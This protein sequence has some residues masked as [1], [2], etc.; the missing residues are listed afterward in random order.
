MATNNTIL[1][2]HF[3]VQR[4]FMPLVTLLNEVEQTD[5]DGEDVS[6]AALREQMTWTGHNP[7][8]DRWVATR[9]DDASLIGYG[10]IFKTPN[11]DCADLYIAVHPAWRRRGVGSELL[12]HLMERAREVGTRVVGAYATVQN[13]AARLF[14]SHHGFDPVA[15]YTRM[16]ILGS[17]SF[18]PPSLPPGFV[19]RSYDQIQRI[20]LYTEATNRSYEGLWGHRHVSQEEVAEWLPHLLPEGIFLLFAP[21]G[22]VVGK[23]Q[24]EISEHLTT[25]RGAPTGLVDAPGI[26]PAY[27]EANLYVPL[28]L[29]VLHWLAPQSPTTIEMESWGDRADT[30]AQY[31]ALGFTPMQEAV[32]YNRNIDNT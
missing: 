30:L 23:C 22:A 5:H 17:Q 9:S 20:D 25:L 19:V 1:Y 31:R 10:A 4:D 12:A 28:L 8:L 2:H 32:S 3:D 29:T 15:A 6:E 7:T 11:D 18:P 27:R 16:E 14:L 24:A 26:I 13:Q 21:D